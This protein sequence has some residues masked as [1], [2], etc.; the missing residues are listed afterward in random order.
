MCPNGLMRFCADQMLE[1]KVKQS[2]VSA[3]ATGPDLP[4]CGGGFMYMLALQVL[5]FMVNMR[6]MGLL[7]EEYTTF[8]MAQ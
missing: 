6:V 8:I 1:F 3:V 5:Y 2:H 4:S 7:C